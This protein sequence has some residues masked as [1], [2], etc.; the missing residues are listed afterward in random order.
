MFPCFLLK[1]NSAS[2]APPSPTS[3]I[4]IV[5]SHISKMHFKVS[6]VATHYNN[7][8]TTTNLLVID[9]C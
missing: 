2:R 7:Y 5:D 3:A 1:H 9:H 6:L 4:G 8:I